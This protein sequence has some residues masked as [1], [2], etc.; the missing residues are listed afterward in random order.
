M[1]RFQ[2]CSGKSTYY[3]YDERHHLVAV[4]DA[5]NTTTTLERK[6]DGEVLRINHPDGTH[7]TFT[8]NELGQVPT[9]TDGKGQTTQLLRNG[10]GLPKWRQDAKGQTITYEYDKAIRLV[11][12]TNEN[13]ATYR[14]AYDDADRLIEEKR[15]DN[16]TRRFSYNLGGHLTQVEEIGYGEKGEQPRRSTHLERDPI[17]RLLAKLNDDA[18]QDYAYEYDPLSNL[19]TLTLPTGQHL[20]HLYYG[21]GHLHQMNLDGQLISDME[22]DD[23]H[24]EIY[25]TQG[26][27]TSCFGYDSMGR[28]AWQ[29][30]TTLPA[31]KLSQIQNPLIK[32][33]RYVEHAY[34]PIHR[35]YEYDP[36]GELS[37]TLDK[38]RG[39]TQYEYE[40]NGQLLAR[41]TGRVV[42]GEEFRYDAAANRLNFNTSRFDHVK[43]N[44]LKQWANHEYKYDA[45]GNLIEKVVGIVRWQTFTYDCENR[46]VKTETMADTQVESTS[47]YQYDSLGRRVAKQSEIKGHTE[48]KRFL[49]QGLRMLR[50]ES[51]GQ[52]SLYFYEP[53]S[54]APLARVGEKEGEV[55]NKVYYFHTYQIGT[56]LEMTDAEGQIVWQAKYRAWGAVEKLVVNEVEQNLRFQGQYFDVETGLH[57]NTFRY[58]DPE[59][60]RFITQDPIGL[61]GGFNLYRYTPNPV[62]WTDALGLVHEL[63]PGYNVYGLF[64]EGAE[65]PYYVGV[66]DDLARR[67]NE[68]IGTNRLGPGTEMVPLD[69]NVNYGQARGYEQAYI[70]HYET[71][72]GVIGKEISPANRGNKINSFDHESTLRAPSRQANFESSYQTKSSALKGAC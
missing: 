55:E 20:N 36:A 37:R 31:E 68:H 14:F 6:P 5:L 59:I 28:K 44:R 69:K 19:T 24:R 39:E 26:K 21:S 62:R 56:P 17:G 51:P 58:Y 2:D 8:Y 12:L 15:I 23:L 38:L 4:T 70:E 27:L 60:G 72:T 47:S 29:Y 32:P 34:N 65:K 46:L 13:D 50:E 3:R 9:H 57:Y 18:R 61:L 54:Y 41:N 1:Q 43:D 10:R 16:L 49:W 48:H 33:E 64:Q 22:R 63:T 40:A 66:T 67:R 35:R 11:A 42:D 25:R 7:E 53:G 52:S 45:W 30:A 71:K